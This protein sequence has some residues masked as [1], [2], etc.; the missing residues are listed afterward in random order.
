MP[1][2]APATK[3]DPAFSPRYPADAMLR[4]PV[5]LSLVGRSKAGWYDGIA[6]GVFPPP[7]RVGKRAVAWP[8]GAIYALLDKLA[9]GEVFGQPQAG[10]RELV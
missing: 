2:I 8:A 5:V 9:A 1:R 7:V 10:R 6:K 3:A 4:L